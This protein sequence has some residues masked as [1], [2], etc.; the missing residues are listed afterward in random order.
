MGYKIEN[1]KD[2]TYSREIMQSKPHGFSKYMLYI[3]ISLLILI[4]VWSLNSNKD[5]I[6]NV[7]GE[8]RPSSEEISISSSIDGI[9]TNIKYKDGDKIKK[10]DILLTVNSD[11]LISQKS[12]LEKNLEKN[13]KSLENTKKLKE[14]ILDN[15]NYF[16]NDINDKEFYE[17]F[18]MYTD[19][20]NTVSNQN[21]LIITQQQDLQKKLDDY[22]LFIQ[23]ISDNVNHLNTSSALYY[24]YEEYS[25]N[26]NDYNKKIQIYEEDINNVKSDISLDEKDKL[27]RISII[28]ANLNETKSLLS[29]YV[30]SQN[31][32][33]YSSIEQIQSQIKELELSISSSN[34]KEQYISN[35]NTTIQTLENNILDL[36]TNIESYNIKIKDSSIVAQSDGILSTTASIKEGDYLQAGTKI[37]SIIPED[38]SSYIVNLYIRPQDF[39]NIKNGQ[40]ISISIISL[41]KSEYGFINGKINNISMDTKVDSQSG[42]NY[43]TAE[44]ITDKTYLT[45][46]KGEKVYL[47]PGMPVDGKIISRTVSYFRYFLEKINVSM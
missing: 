28:E 10:G 15:I 33:I 41:P 21:N 4:L 13:E 1:L 38:I 12:L 45:N 42:I 8:I 40:D 37:G 47:K 35:L 11:E 18:K 44:L 7:S 46:K 30:N 6:T 39:A 20:F 2:I 19:S 23:S 14:S 16:E 29:K 34:I 5:I 27:D 26:I 31:T 9:I 32:A 43:Y 3:I 25:F 17:K 24:S 36:N 22:N